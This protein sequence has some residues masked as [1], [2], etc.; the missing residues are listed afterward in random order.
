MNLFEEAR[1]VLEV[2]GYVTSAGQTP[3]VFNFEDL[4]LFGFVRVTRSVSEIIQQWQAGQDE[5]LRKNDDQLRKSR[6]KSW[7][8]YSVFLTADEPSSDEVNALA[9]VEE[10]FRG[11]RK[12]TGT[13]LHTSGHVTRALLPLI[14][15]QNPVDLDNEDALKRLLTRLTSM[16]PEV[17]DALSRL[18][19]ATELKE[20]L[21]RSHED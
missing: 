7:N 10:D 14:P 5:F 13:G 2:A 21:L 9:R 16:P 12:L 6:E 3:D 15:I 18:F 8:V 17:L 11:T 20:I 19:S 4:S 1:K